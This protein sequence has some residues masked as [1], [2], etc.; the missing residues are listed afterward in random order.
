[1]RL[2]IKLGIRKIIRMRTRIKARRSVR[3]STP[4]RRCLT[5]MDNDDAEDVENT[6]ESGLTG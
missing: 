1:M 3:G 2:K 4:R 5:S 6:K